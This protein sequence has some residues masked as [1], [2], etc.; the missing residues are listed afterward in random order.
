MSDM[1]LVPQPNDEKVFRQELFIP[2]PGEEYKSI[3]TDNNGNVIRKNHSYFLGAYD[4]TS[5]K[6][7]LKERLEENKGYVAKS[8]V[9]GYGVFAKDD[10]KAGDIIEECPVVILDGSHNSNKDWVLNRYAF[11]WSCMCNICQKNGQSMCIPMGNGMIYN[12]SDNPNAYYIQDSFF[13]IFRFY[14][15][16][17]IKKDEEITWFY[18]TGYS[19]RLKKEKTLSPLGMMPE[20]IPQSTPARKGC[21][22]GARAKEIKKEDVAPQLLVEEP[23][24]TETADELLFR[25][26]IVPEN[27]LND[28]V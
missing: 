4:S 23:V 6:F 1:T 10:I 24:K 3:E 25:S 9:S 26:M 28:K 20:G 11:T 2:K 7:V 21:G 15:F 5:N 22:C 18:G 27:I 8:P 14:A 19:E 17:D 16:R 13:R 12:H